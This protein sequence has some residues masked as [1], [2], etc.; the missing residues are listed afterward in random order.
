MVSP[1][2]AII[3]GPNG[4]GKTTFAMKNFVDEVA[5]ECF[6]NV[7]QMA[8][9]L[10]QVDPKLTDVEIARQALTRR[11]NLIKERRSFLIETTLATLALKQAIRQAKALGFRVCLYYLWI[12][13]PR[14][15]DFRVKDRVS[16][17][18]HN[19]PLE[20]ILRRYSLSLKYFED[21]LTIVDRAYIYNADA[22]PELIAYKEG[23]QM[24]VLQE[25]LWDSFIKEVKLYK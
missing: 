9:Q 1:T 16:K 19:I 3:A 24:Q 25:N 10:R 2:L 15:C 20:V 6:V 13:S 14:L 18:G 11:N 17:G 8:Y 22:Q 4:A 12:S 21:Y 5:Q 23:Q 7:D